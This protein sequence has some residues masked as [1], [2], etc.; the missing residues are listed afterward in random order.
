MLR[1]NMSDN[2]AAHSQKITHNYV[3]KHGKC[4]LCGREM[5]R[6][7]TDHEHKTD[8]IRGFICYRCN[9]LLGIISDDPSLLITATNY[10][11]NPPRKGSYKEYERLYRNEWGKSE[12]QRAKKA[13]YRRKWIKTRFGSNSSY[14]QYCREKGLVV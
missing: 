1:I 13:E 6:L 7:L 11:D 10:L 8:R 4:D 12:E 9:F 14:K 2:I 5:Q 3:L